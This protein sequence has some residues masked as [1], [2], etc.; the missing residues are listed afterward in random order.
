MSARTRALTARDRRVA[1]SLA[2][3]PG[4]TNRLIEQGMASVTAE[5]RLSNGRYVRR[6]R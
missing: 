5:W 2:D 6:Q 1:R 3:D 4:V